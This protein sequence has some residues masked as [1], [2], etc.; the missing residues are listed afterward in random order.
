VTAPA[1]EPVAGTEPAGSDTDDESVL[2]VTGSAGDTP[3]TETPTA[4][5]PPDPDKPDPEPGIAP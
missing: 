3:D 1:G 5:T 2:R 4:V